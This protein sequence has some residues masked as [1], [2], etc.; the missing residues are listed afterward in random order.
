MSSYEDIVKQINANGGLRTAQDLETLY[1]SKLTD[2]QV[3]DVITK[4]DAVTA[5][6]AGKRQQLVA[7]TDLAL[8]TLRIALLA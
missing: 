4:L 7:F 1:S 3:L 5:T 6:V 2:E 8:R